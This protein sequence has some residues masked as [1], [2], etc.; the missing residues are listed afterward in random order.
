MNKS[1]VLLRM[2]DKLSDGAGIKLAEWCEEYKL[3]VA[4]FRRYIALLR[5]CCKETCG[6]ELV[7]DPVGAVYRL[8]TAAEET[9]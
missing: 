4:T 5:T 9:A 6:R 7:Y 3:S 2:Y 8:R 1:Y